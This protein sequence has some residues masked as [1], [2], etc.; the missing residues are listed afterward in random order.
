V[1]AATFPLVPRRRVI[2]LAFGG[3]RSARRGL[4][5]D[6]ASSRPY[7]PGDN[8]DAIDWAASAKISAAR[9]SDE[10]IVRE[11]YAEESPR[12]VVVADRRPA[13]ALQAPPRGRLRKHEALTHA[14]E[15]ISASA[16]VSRSLV[17][18]LDFM[19][20]TAFW[21]AP[22]TEHQKWFER[23]DAA[24]DAPE[25]TLDRSLALLESH[26]GALPM[27]T[28]VFVVSD[29]L[30]PPPLAAWRRALGH[31]WDVVPVVIQDPLWERS[32][33]DVHGVGIPFA[34]PHTGTVRYVKL[35]KYEVRELREANETRFAA[36]MA[37]F[38]GLG[39]EPVVLDS[40]DPADIGAAFLRWADERIYVRGRA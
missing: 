22:R 8:I 32:F 2:G 5:S 12:V 24:F 20:G 10:F 29:F 39:F 14:I 1:P 9:G 40:A 11:H 33:P 18:Y 6:V 26:R 19:G 4:G 23:G 28:F 7:R 36:L 25:D 3:M 15:L 17:G 27:G 31:H 30:A 34:D 37:V 35:S 21:K 16:A 38:R 13:M